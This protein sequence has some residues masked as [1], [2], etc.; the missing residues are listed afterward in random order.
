MLVVFVFKL[1][2]IKKIYDY[3]D[4]LEL[5]SFLLVLDY[6]CVW[7]GYIYVVEFYCFFFLWFDFSC[8]EFFKMVI[9]ENFVFLWKLL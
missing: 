9:K 3:G 8:G 7:L 6:C 1:V 2:L 4:V 5:F